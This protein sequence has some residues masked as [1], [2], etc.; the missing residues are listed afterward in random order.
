MTRASRLLRPARAA[1]LLLGLAS[2]AFAVEGFQYSR[3]VTV[4]QAGRVRV[5]LDLAAV[6]HM[7]PGGADLH[8]FGPGG[9]QVPARVEPWLP[10]SEQRDVEVVSVDSREDGWTLLLD[11]GP[12]PAPHERL[13]FDLARTTAAPAVRLEGS[14]DGEDWRTLAVGDLFRIGRSGGLARTALAYPATED[15]YLRLSWPDEAGFPR[16][17]AVEVETVRGPTLTHTTPDAKCRSTGPSSV[18]CELSLP[19]PGQVLRRLTLEV[20]GSGALGYGLDFAEEGRWHRLAE[21]V[22]HTPASLEGPGRRTLAGTREPIPGS[23]LRLALY[24]AA[25]APSLARWTADL[26]VPTVVFEAPQPGR[27]AL[28]YGGPRRGGRESLPARAADAGGEGAWLTATPERVG[29]LP[30][31]AGPAAAPGNPLGPTRFRRSWKVLA[32]GAKPGDLIRLELPAAVYGEARPDLADLRLAA[33]SR[34]V[35]YARWTPPEPALAAEA[36]GLQPRTPGRRS[37]LSEAALA[38]PAR[39]LPLTSLHLTAPG[40]P[41]RRTVEVLYPAPGAPGRRARNGRERPP[42]ARDVWRCDPEPPLPCQERLPLPGDAPAEIALR[43]HDGDNP[44]LSGL[45]ATVCAGSAAG[46]R[47]APA[48]RAAL[49]GGSGRAPP[50]GRRWPATGGR[51]P[52]PGPRPHQAPEVLLVEALAGERLDAALQGEQVKAAAGARKPPA[53]SAACRAAGPRAEARMR[54]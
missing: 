2:P 50:A 13:V 18:A 16:V 28:A 42:V 4:P 51:C 39:A 34:Q 3:E 21:G 27:Y 47:R 35:P 30:P 7:A 37:R 32:P 5:A 48:A 10:R 43:I 54:R 23:T 17:S 33:G 45:G 29:K 46:R 19:A 8:V 22:W 44:P 24:G 14:P 31:L 41:L 25:Q 11:V 20:D 40:G 1:V 6:Q 15:R 26:A 12:E 53:G 49:R 38:L 36:D 52:P 9:A